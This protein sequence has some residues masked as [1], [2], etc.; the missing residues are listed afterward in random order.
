[1]TAKEYLQ[2]IHRLS[3]EIRCNRRRISEIESDISGL[4]AI[5]YSG[6]KVG[7][8]GD[9]DQMASKIA[10][11]VDLEQRIADE[12]VELQEKKGKIIKEIRQLKDARYV[13]L[14]TTRYV[15]CDMWERI[16][17]DMHLTIRRVYQMHG[18]ALKAFEKQ[19]MR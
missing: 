2:Q 4:K 9:P 1:M 14:L 5:D 16:A 19:N 7:G 11:L 18:E 10:R 13:T 8:S 6:D 17:V 12:T 15:N 3:E